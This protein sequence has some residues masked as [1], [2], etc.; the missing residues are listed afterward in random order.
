MSRVKKTFYNE[1]LPQL[2]QGLTQF[3][4]GM[5]DPRKPRDNWSKEIPANPEVAKFLIDFARDFGHTCDCQQISFLETLF[6]MISESYSEWFAKYLKKNPAEIPALLFKQMDFWT[7]R[8][9]TRH[10]KY[11][12]YTRI[13]INIHAYVVGSFTHGQRI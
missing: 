4:T 11:E 12:E 2:Y 5:I 10:T 7:N 3:Y 9:C 6:K 8:Q 13:K 1:F